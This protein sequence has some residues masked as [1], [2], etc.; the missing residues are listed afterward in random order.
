MELAVTLAVSLG[1]TLLLEGLFALLWGV[2]RRDMPLVVLANVLTNPTVVV[3]HR[4]AALFAPGLLA[5]VTLLLE[6]GAVAV[7]GW[8]YR[9][10][11]QIHLPWAFAVCANLFSYTIGLIL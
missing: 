1:L 4:T 6:L 7:E 3:L 8:M 10:R 2:E 5:P 11:S 9:E